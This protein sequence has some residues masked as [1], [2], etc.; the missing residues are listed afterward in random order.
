MMKS[1]TKRYEMDTVTNDN[2]SSDFAN[3][4]ID[5]T[6]SV[7][8]NGIWYMIGFFGIL[9]IILGRVFYLSY[10]LLEKERDEEDEEENAMI[11][12]K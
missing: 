5:A 7:P 8:F 9:I 1:S 4:P 3:D 6:S 12:M 10:R 11:L 2:F